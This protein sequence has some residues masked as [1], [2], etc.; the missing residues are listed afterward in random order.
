MTGIWEERAEVSLLYAHYGVMHF[1][2]GPMNGD[3]IE[4][5]A[6]GRNCCALDASSAPARIR[7]MLEF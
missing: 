7:I 3:Q 5:L 6:F 2:N 4:T 1:H